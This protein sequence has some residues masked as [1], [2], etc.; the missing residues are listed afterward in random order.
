VALT[1]KWIKNV[2]ILVS[3]RTLKYLVRGGR[4]SRVKGWIARI[5]NINPIVSLDN[6][7]KTIL[8]DKAFSQKANMKKVMKHIR[9]G[10]SG[11]RYGII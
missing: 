2:R 7:G 3:V 10:C 1:Q 4:V 11:K 8:F 9:E 6:E 5:L